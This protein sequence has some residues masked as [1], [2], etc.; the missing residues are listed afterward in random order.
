M[1]PQPTHALGKVVAATRPSNALRNSDAV[2]ATWKMR[3]RN[4]VAAVLAFVV[5]PEGFEFSRTPLRPSNH[6]EP[7]SSTFP[8]LP[9][10]Y[11]PVTPHT[12]RS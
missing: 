12:Q 4:A 3:L 10:E 11:D 7:C 5:F 9:Y 1:H 2:D 8:I 6:G